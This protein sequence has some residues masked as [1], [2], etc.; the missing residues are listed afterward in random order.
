[1]T[2]ETARSMKRN[3]HPIRGAVF[4]LLLGFFAMLDLLLVGTIRIDSVVVYLVPILGLLV[5]VALGSW[6]PFGTR[7]RHP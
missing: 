3:G 7:S 5:G 6:A 4:G 2:N 1:M